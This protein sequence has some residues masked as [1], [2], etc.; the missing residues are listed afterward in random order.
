MKIR[1]AIE[2]PGPP[3]GEVTSE[4][5]RAHGGSGLT[6]RL[7]LA[8]VER[9]AG[10]Q[11][12]Q[13]VLETA[14]LAGQEALMQDENHWFSYETKIAL[15][16]AAEEVL[17]DPRIAEHAG[18][19]VLELSVAMALKR[20]LRALGTPGYVYNN[21][22]R[23]SGKFNWAQQME[24]LHS[25]KE[26]VRMRLTDVS[27]V[28]YHRYDCEY[29][30]GLLAIVPKLF[31]LPL[32]QVRHTVCGVDGGP[33]CEFEVHWT[34]G[35]HGLK[36][37]AV[38][39]AAGSAVL[40]GA[41]V[42]LEPALVPVAGGLLVAGEAVLGLRALGFMRRRLDVLEV[43]VREQDDAAER[44]LSSLQ[45]L[46]SDL[47]LDEVLG[48]ITAKAQTAIGGKEFALLVAER[49]C[50]R[51]DRHSG[52]SPASLAALSAWARATAPPCSTAAQSSSTTSPQIRRCSACST[53]RVRPSDRSAPRRSCSAT[54]CSACWP[55]SP[56]ARPCSSPAT[57]QR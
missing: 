12:V 15:W 18:A 40:A 37:L 23:A 39:L 9:E 54:S 5:R 50:M 1:S 34:A 44:L 8:Y 35:T 49:G 2:R 46:S 30:K 20:T 16:S 22:V 25:D 28:G 3:D 24:V 33:C 43:R 56:M 57:P 26:Y 17:E 31:G 19:A 47:R 41:G 4:W 52:I 36:R 45:D 21:V 7:I 6:S 42:L 38:G 48:Q 32:A 13:R 11:A 51:A 10:G 55:R 14:D 53:R 27:G 29:T